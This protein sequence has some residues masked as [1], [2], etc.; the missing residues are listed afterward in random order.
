MAIYMKA[1]DHEQYFHVALFIM[2]HK[3]VLTLESVKE[4]L[5]VAI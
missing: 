4:I 5:C 2:M 3:V 1:I